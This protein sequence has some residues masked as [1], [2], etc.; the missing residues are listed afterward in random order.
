M[1]LVV[2]AAEQQTAVRVAL[3]VHK[4]SRSNYRG[5]VLNL[6]VLTGYCYSAVNLTADPEGFCTREAAGEQPRAAK[7]DGW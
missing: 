6:T 3:A 1:P 2:N 7:A 4:E 5:A